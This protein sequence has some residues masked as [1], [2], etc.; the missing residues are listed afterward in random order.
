MPQQLTLGKTELDL[1]S[2]EPFDGLYGSAPLGAAIK[3][4]G[5][6]VSDLANR[7]QQA[8]Q[9]RGYAAGCT[10]RQLICLRGQTFGTDRLSC[11]QAMKTAAR[12]VL[13]PGHTRSGCEARQFPAAA[14]VFSP[15]GK[16]VSAWRGRCVLF[17][18]VGSHFPCLS[19]NSICK[20]NPATK[21]GPRSRLYPGLEAYCT[22]NA[23]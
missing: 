23:G 15:S 4:R 22:S 11:K 17:T 21:T 18:F 13:N 16:Y 12:R 1:G 8:N 14:N 20:R 19:Q 9:A 3:F 2:G 7:S 5:I 10:V 6:F